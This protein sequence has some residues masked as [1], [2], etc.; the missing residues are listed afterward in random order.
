MIARSHQTPS[1]ASQMLLVCSIP[2]LMREDPEFKK[3]YIAALNREV[4]IMGRQ[5]IVRTFETEADR[6]VYLL[7][8]FPDSRRFFA[9]ETL[10]AKIAER[11]AGPMATAIVN[12]YIEGERERQEP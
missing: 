9:F 3:P 6:T 10:D 5:Q 7:R 8:E 11:L 1:E 4:P 2:N 12:E